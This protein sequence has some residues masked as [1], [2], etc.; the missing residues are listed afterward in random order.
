MSELMSTIALALIVMW[1]S[2]PRL[3]R[4][5]DAQLARRN[6][7]AHMNAKTSPSGRFR[8]ASPQRGTTQSTLIE[9]ASLCDSLARATRGGTSPSEAMSTSI[10]RHHLVGNHWNVLTQAEYSVGQFSDS[11]TTALQIAG[12][13]YAHDDV[14]CL[15]LISLAIIHNNLVPAA[16]DHAS[17]ILRDIAACRSDM[18]V[19][20]SQ[21]RLSARMLTALPFVLCAG[22]IVISTSFRSALTSAPVLFFLALGLILN[23]IG[24]HWISRH[25]THSMS[26]HPSN[27]EL[28]TDHLC[29]SLR[30]GL[31]ITQACER[32]KD[33]SPM[34]TRIAHSLESGSTLEDSLHPLATSSDLSDR[35]LVDVVMQAERDG[36]PVLSTV[37]RLSTE[38]RTERRR[39]IDL[40]IRQLPTRLSVPL[41][42]CVLPSFLLMSIAPLILASLSHLSISL[43]S[44]TS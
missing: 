12:H 3:F 30:A 38:T 21:A 26:E 44:V 5:T 17:L 20:A 14:R 42:L 9:L 29:V 32:W 18:A 37:H 43:P 22:A 35:A 39:M 4:L 25:I 31:T 27:A 40:R 8:F 13:A 41:V 16:L 6:L 1:W 19:A 7:F 34:G 15:T 33:T 28:L 23:R 11:V 24:W 2:T 10:E 36:L